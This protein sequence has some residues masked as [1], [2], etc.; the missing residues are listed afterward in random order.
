LSIATQVQPVLVP[1]TNA[2]VA[3]PQD[4]P[5]IYSVN[6]N[7]GQGGFDFQVA[8]VFGNR[9]PDAYASLD[10]NAPDVTVGGPSYRIAL[11]SRRR[12]DVLVVDF[13]APV[14]GIVVNP[15]TAVGRAAWISLAFFLRIAAAVE[16]DVD[17]LELEAGFRNYGPPGQPLAQAFLS[18]KLENGAGYCRWLAD[19]ANFLGVL[20]QADSGQVFRWA[21]LVEARTVNG[22][23]TSHEDGPGRAAVPPLQGSVPS[24]DAPSAG[25][26]LVGLR[27]HSA[28]LRFT[29]HL[30]P[31]RF[32]C[33]RCNRSLPLL[34]PLWGGTPRCEL[35]TAH[36][37][38][39]F[40]SCRQTFQ[41][42]IA[43][44]KAF[45]RC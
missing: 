14:P 28:R 6:D 27:P 19:P 25:L 38:A 3:S 16:L 31:Y 44:T 36:D 9:I 34:L 10:Q 42:A 29:R 35:S 15:E 32:R 4:P 22:R 24:I 37:A 12:T 1:T 41:R 8:S 45:P 23:G 13:A 2:S 11:L 7:D 30:P 5:E 43:G 33:R 26:S 20:G 21:H 17:T 18:D 39:Q 40:V